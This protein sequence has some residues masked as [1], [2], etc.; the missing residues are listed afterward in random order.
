MTRSSADP[1]PLRFI[2]L[3]AGIGGFHLAFHGKPVQNVFPT[4]CVFVSEWDKYART[5]YET[6]FKKLAPRIFETSETSTLASSSAAPG[7]AS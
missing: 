7:L 5:T 1:T 2:D 3:F 6:Y 4:E